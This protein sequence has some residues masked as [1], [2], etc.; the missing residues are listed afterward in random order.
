MGVVIREGSVCLRLFALSGVL[1]VA[2]VV[3]DS[4]VCGLL[5]HVD[6]VMYC[7]FVLCLMLVAVHLN[8]VESQTAMIYICLTRCT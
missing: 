3:D 6:V 2:A 7:L 5:R 1:L 8:K 4:G